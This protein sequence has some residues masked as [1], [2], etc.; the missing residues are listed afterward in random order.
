MVIFRHI[1]LRNISRNLYNHFTKEI[2]T[3]DSFLKM[4]CHLFTCTML[5]AEGTQRRLNPKLR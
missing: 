2:S 3:L 5:G 4:N 1:T